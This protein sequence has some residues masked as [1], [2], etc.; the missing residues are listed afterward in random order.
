MNPLLTVIR[1][2]YRSF[3]L[4]LLAITVLLGFYFLSLGSETY[5]PTTDQKDVNT[6][7]PYQSV[8]TTIAEDEEMS[9]SHDG[10]D[11]LRV[12]NLF[13]SCKGEDDIIL[14]DTYID[15]YEELCKLFRLFGTIFSFVTSDVEEK[16]NILR[17]YRKSDVAEKYKTIQSLL[18]YEVE[19]GTAKNTKKP[20][21]ARTL[22]RLHRALE[23]IAAF[24]LKLKETDNTVKFSSAAMKAYDDTLARHHPWLV[25]KAVHVAMYM[26]PSRL[27]LL[28]K[29][30][31]EDNERGMQGISDLAHEL[32]VIFQVTEEAYSQDNLLDLP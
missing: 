16:I 25:K 26:L 15:A 19:Q 8:A 23:F 27:D 4:V 2:R 32:T 6:E 1:Q 17:D 24:L 29:M 20:S 5:G 3:L 30:G 11:A 7:V 14:L 18:E 13:T 21:G 22:L 9:H 31:V 28:K 10:F 12:Y